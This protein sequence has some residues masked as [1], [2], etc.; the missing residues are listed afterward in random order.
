MQATGGFRV[1]TLSRLKYRHVKH[2]LERKIVPVCVQVEA[3]ITKGKYRSYFTFLNQEAVDYLNAYL[4][5]RRVGTSKLP[6]EQIQDESPLIRSAVRSAGLLIVK[7]V[8]PPAIQYILHELYFKAGLMVRKS[9]RKRYDLRAHSLRKF[10]QTELAA[11][12]VEHDCVEF[13]MGHGVT[14]YN[15]LK[16]RGVEYLRG[17]YLTAGL[18]IKPKERLSKIEALKEIIVS[19]GLDP[20]KILSQQILTE[21]EK[22]TDIEKGEFST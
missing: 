13:M 17:V 1:G 20:N 8:A 14:R 15:D 12:G 6:P 18:T 22:Q 2:D 10:F 5:L 21:S 11:R 16:A 3:E 19:W 4:Q 7:P 9:Q